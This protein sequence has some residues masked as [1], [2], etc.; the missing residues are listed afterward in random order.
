MQDFEHGLS[1]ME[2][3]CELKKVPFDS[4]HIPDYENIHVQQ[5]YF[6]RYF[7]A[8]LVE[9]YLISR[10]LISYN[11]LSH[12]KMFSLGCGANIDYYG[13]YYALRDHAP[14]EQAGTFSYTGLDKTDWRYKEDL[15]RRQYCYI[16][17]DISLWNSLDAADY[18]VI[19]FPKSIGEFSNQ[20]FDHVKTMLSHSNFTERNIVLISSVRQQ[21]SPT[22]MYRFEIIANLLRKN[23]GYTNLDNSTTYYHV[24]DTGT[25]FGLSKCCDAFYYPD[26][27]KHFL[28]KLQSQCPIFKKHR[29]SCETDCQD[30]LNR[31]PI[32]TARYIQFQINRFTRE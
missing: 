4:S 22:D 5:L 13:F 31:N 1:S 20:V 3:L 27:I 7:P 26:T 24:R 14:A 29:E 8:S 15:G 6:L 32:L 17:G 10:K 19:I 25:G 18:N 9:Y 21:H 12:Y 28:E 2:R 23:F 11:F 30:L 16:N